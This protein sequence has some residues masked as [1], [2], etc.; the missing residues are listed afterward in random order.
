MLT[1]V[2]LNISHHE[3]NW[4]IISYLQINFFVMNA[5]PP[6]MD[7]HLCFC[8]LANL[9]IQIQIPTIRTKG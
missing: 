7:A 9:S 8:K 3:I 5:A 4:N 1:L 6:E 2:L